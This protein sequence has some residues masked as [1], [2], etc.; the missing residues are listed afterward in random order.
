[1]VAQFG[2][3][4]AGRMDVAQLVVAAAAGREDAAVTLAPP[5]A[6]RDPLHP[7]RGRD[8]LVGELLRLCARES[9]GRVHVLHGMSGCGKTAVLLEL[10]HRLSGAGSRRVWW[11]DARHAA[12]FAAGMRAVARQV[13]LAAGDVRGDAADVLWE[14]L[15]GSARPWLLIVDNAEDLRVLDG[16][17]R[18]AA[19]TGWLR[20]HGC[21]GGVVVA[22]TRHGVGRMWG[23]AA[24]LHAVRPLS[25]E[26]AA[27]VLVDHAGGQAGAVEA[28]RALGVRL[29]GLP[30]ALSMAGSYL[31][32]VH[33][34]PGAFRDAGMPSDFSSYH[35]ALSERDSSLNPA[36]VIAHAWQMSIRLLHQMGFVHAGRLLTVLAA[37]SEA[38]VPYTL[39]LRPAMLSAVVS[40]LADLDGTTLWR[41]L[42]EL[43]AL[44]LVDPLD[45]S[46][47]HGG[48]PCVRLHP[49]I[50]DIARAETSTAVTLIE[51][52]LRLEEVR[53][54]PEDPQSWP[55]WAAL[56]PHALDLLQHA[57]AGRDQLS[58]TQRTV[59]AD[60]A[61]LAAR[62]LQTQ[63]LFPQ[64]RLE[65]ERVL[66]VRRDVLGSEH[67]ETITT[68]HNL[69]S[70]LHDLGE[71][72]EA[73]SLR[74]RVWRALE[75]VHG[76]EHHD[77]LTARHELG[78]LL[79]DLERLD[80]AEAHLRGVFAIRLQTGGEQDPHTLAARHELARVLHDRGDLEAARGEYQALLAIRVARLGEDHPRTATTRHN[81]ACVL[82]D[83]G[84]LQLAHDEVQLALAAR[85]RLYGFAHPKTMATAHLLATVLHAQSRGEEARRM[86]EQVCEAG[87]RLLGAG[88]LQTRRYTQTLARFTQEGAGEPGEG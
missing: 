67:L 43:A 57:G 50:R 20:P 66:A 25:A 81:H 22:A 34:M 48:L 83:M 1:M 59:C 52:A 21:R 62:Y 42:R 49:L 5:V 15:G 58:A 87:L 18:L 38:P 29:G 82:H 40:G 61:E 64:A 46:A 28:A 11:V 39:L 60:A 19:G 14:E 4:A 12:T 77:T 27:L 45:V 63:G 56:T 44:G 7:L 26:D 86:M 76:A 79:H 35:R 23:R 17:G 68:Q 71:L 10:V 41:T 80:E 13:G 30:L 75:R 31:A 88:H 16:P 70:V 53:V 51:Q 6:E 2:G 78:R 69:A 65:F 9:D 24:V 36:R 33:G 47:Q 85:R 3:V 54:P 32:E 37:F 73:E 72:E 8:A 84:H 74:R 55:A